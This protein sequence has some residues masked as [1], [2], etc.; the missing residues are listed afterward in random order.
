MHRR[1]ATSRR[2]RH[3]GRRRRPRPRRRR[4]TRSPV[5]APGAAVTCAGL[6][7]P[8]EA[9]RG[10]V[11]Y[12][13]KVDADGD[14]DAHYVL[15]TKRSITLLG[16]TAIDVRAGLRPK[17]LPRVGEWVSAAGPV[18]TG[19]YGQSQIHALRIRHHRRV[20]PRR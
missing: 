4:P 16:L 7:P 1:A 11:Y 14:G 17:R 15:S 19:S 13:E 2:R 3:R 8:C 10:R 18:Q 20:R 9:V 12:V 5:R 6:A